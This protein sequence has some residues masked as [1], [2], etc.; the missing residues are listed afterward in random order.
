VERSD[1]ELTPESLR[2]I[3]H[4]LGVGRAEV[5][6]EP[7]GERLLPWFEAEGWTIERH[8]LMRHHGARP[9]PPPEVEPA[10]PEAFLP[11]RREWLGTIPGLA[12]E[13]VQRQ[14]AAALR[15]SLKSLAIRGFCVRAEGRPVAMA[16]LIEGAMIEDVFTSESHRGR[17]LGA[18][19]VCGALAA[20]G[21]LAYLATDADGLARP[22]YERLG[23]AGEGV[24]TIFIA[25]LPRG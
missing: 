5:W 2:D 10:D 21:P 6:D 4:G 15:R 22:L 8:L 12:D 3:A 9:A 7:T 1:P 20:A 24:V 23:F 16:S 13:E 17:G 19:V 25:P 18:A 11:L 14:G